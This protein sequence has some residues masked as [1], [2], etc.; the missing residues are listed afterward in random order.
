[1]KLEIRDWMSPDVVDVWNWVPKTPEDVHFLLEVDIGEAGETGTYIFQVLVATPEGV[2]WLKRT[3]SDW[4]LPDRGLLVLT[5][6]SWEALEEQVQTIVK[7]CEGCTWR[8][9]VKCLHPH[10]HWEYE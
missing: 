3:Y 1:M 2:E 6:Y 7:S 9:V 8:D 10:F 5:K 4:S